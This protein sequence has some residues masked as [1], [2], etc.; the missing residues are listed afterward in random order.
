MS[1]V[2]G[3]SLPAPEKLVALK[4]ADCANDRGANAYPSLATI[5]EACGLSRRG[6]QLVIDRLLEKRCL[7]VQADHTNRRSTIYRLRL[8]AVPGGERRA[9]LDGD[10]RT[11]SQRHRGE[12]R[13]PLEANDVHPADVPRGE[14]CSP[15]EANVVPPGGERGAPLEA[16]DVHPIRHGSVSEPSYTPRARE[17]RRSH[18]LEESL[19]LESWSLRLFDELWALYPRKDVRVASMRAWYALNPP[20]ELG[21]LIVAHVRVRLTLGWA[22]D[23]PP[24]FLPQL[25]TFLEERRWQE[26]YVAP[27]GREAGNASLPDGL[28]V[29]Q[30]C[31]S[32]GATQEG[33]MVEGRANYAACACAEKVIA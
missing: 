21:E 29:M 33:R 26:R 17:G 13:A 16:N 23:T 7:E 14:R 2:W 10:E 11:A 31:P 5:A 27:A 12:R 4:L 24:R 28:L 30:S 6:T 25:R 18:S 19:A 9:P 32:C 22:R 1:V 20:R 15:L 8:D 3:W